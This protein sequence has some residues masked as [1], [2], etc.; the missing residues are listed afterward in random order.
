MKVKELERS[1]RSEGRQKGK[2]V[3]I[4]SNECLCVFERQKEREEKEGVDGKSS[5]VVVRLCAQISA[6]N[7]N[8]G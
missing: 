6:S 1:K 4:R 5:P 2:K 8:G 7:S 3:W